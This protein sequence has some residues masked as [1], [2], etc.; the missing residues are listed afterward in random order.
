MHAVTMGYRLFIY[1]LC[2]S[3]QAVGRLCRLGLGCRLAAGIAGLLIA[4]P[5]GGNLRIV[6]INAGGSAQLGLASGALRAVKSE[7]RGSG[8]ARSQAVSSLYIRG[9]ISQVTGSFQENRS[10]LT[11]LVP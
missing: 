2:H 6:K 9:L 11:W 10:I 8:A 4:Q 1:A 7:A 3:F 5:C